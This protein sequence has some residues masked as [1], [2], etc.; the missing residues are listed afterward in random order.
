MF[1]CRETKDVSYRYT[2]V[3]ILFIKGNDISRPGI[4]SQISDVKLYNVNE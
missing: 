4:L 3:V 1:V 2:R